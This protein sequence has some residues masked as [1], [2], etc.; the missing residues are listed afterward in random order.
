MPARTIEG[1]RATRVPRSSDPFVAINKIDKPS[2]SRSRQNQELA[3][4]GLSHSSG[5]RDPKWSRS[6]P[7]APESRTLLETILLDFRHSEP[8][9]K[10]DASC[11]RRRGWKRNSI[12]GPWR[13]WLTCWSNMGT[14]MIPRAVHRWQISGKVRAMFNDRG[15]P[16]TEADPQLRSKCLDCRVCRKRAR[17]SR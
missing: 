17:A 12:G 5:R 1:D 14:L 11:V 2:E 7:K 3:Q 16:I 8:A 15:E 6:P 9:R 13:W 4:Q 10:S